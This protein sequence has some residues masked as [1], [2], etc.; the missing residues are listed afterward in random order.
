MRIIP[1]NSFPKS[2][3]EDFISSCK[4]YRMD[5]KWFQVKAEEGPIQGK[6]GPIQRTVVV[7]HALSGKGRR[8]E[9]SNASHWN[10]DFENDLANFYYT[11]SDASA[12]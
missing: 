11:K 6:M 1:F 5:P 8:Y 12:N 9:A 3:I 2:E 4:Q 10:V 7:M